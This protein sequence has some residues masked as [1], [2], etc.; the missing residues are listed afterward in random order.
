MFSNWIE[1]FSHTLE[2]AYINIK[3]PWTIETAWLNISPEVFT[4][5]EVLQVEF[6]GGG[7]TT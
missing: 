3:E 5:F 1:R 6:E 4:T 7:P 2:H